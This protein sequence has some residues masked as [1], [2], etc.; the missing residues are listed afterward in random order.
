MWQPPAAFDDFEI[1]RYLGSGGMAYVFLARDT[2]LDRAVAI[3]FVSPTAADP[4]AHERFALEAR[5]IARLHHPNVVGV[6]RFGAVAGHPYLA[7]EYVPG[8]RLDRLPRPLEWQ[9]VLAAEWGSGRRKG[10]LSNLHLGAR[11][12]AGW[13][14]LGKTFKGLTDET[15]RW[16]TE[17]LLAREVARDGH[18]VQVRPELVVEIEFNDVQRSARYP[19]GLALRHARV[20]RYRDDKRAVDADAIEA[21]WAIARADGVVPE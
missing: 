14:M 8:R 16:Q 3:K 12:G 2:V 9:R 1:V 5:G 6:Y 20:V 10:W 17:A 18:V 11:D 15:L 13:A 21:V 4:A 7:Y 19:S